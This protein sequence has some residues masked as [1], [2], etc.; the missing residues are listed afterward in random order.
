[1]PTTV[2]QILCPWHTEKTPSCV[3]KGTVVF[4]FGCGHQAT[5][6]ELRVIMMASGRESELTILRLPGVTD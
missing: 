4:C 1:M 5:V 3:I 2:L 6:E